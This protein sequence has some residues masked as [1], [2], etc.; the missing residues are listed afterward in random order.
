M[1]LAAFINQLL[2]I[3]HRSGIYNTAKK[4]EFVSM[5][6]SYSKK[7]SQRKKKQIKSN[8]LFKSQEGLWPLL[9]KL[10]RRGHQEM[11]PEEFLMW[12]RRLRT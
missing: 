12:L 5:R 2:E 9:S 10:N 8:A 4:T 3:I 11:L 7:K 6:D 1:I